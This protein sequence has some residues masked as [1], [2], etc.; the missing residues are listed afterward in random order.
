MTAKELSELH[1]EL[2]Y[3]NLVQGDVRRHAIKQ[4]QHFATEALKG[5]VYNGELRFFLG[6]TRLL[7]GDL[8]GAF[9]A[10]EAAVAL[11]FPESR[12][13]PYLAE[14]AYLSGDYALVR[15]T[16]RQTLHKTRGRH[17]IPSLRQ[18]AEFWSK[19]MKASS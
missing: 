12:V 9:S 18:A 2:V 6:R 5:Q 3:Q 13:A 7:T 16:L 1:W 8:Y 17:P 14:F 19:P 4:A 11:G 15:Q 10:F